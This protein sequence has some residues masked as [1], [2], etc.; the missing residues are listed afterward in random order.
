MNN[1]IS[2]FNKNFEN[3][4]E[5][6]LPGYNYTR[7]RE[8]IGADPISPS[9]SILVY[10]LIAGVISTILVIGYHFVINEGN[11][12]AVFADDDNYNYGNSYGQ[13]QPMNRQNTHNRNAAQ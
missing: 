2:E 12:D 7:V 11:W 8:Q 13:S 6:S 5:L 1:S 4:I 9:K 3:I 10:I